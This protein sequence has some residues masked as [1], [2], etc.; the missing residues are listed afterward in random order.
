MAMQFITS[1]T[2]PVVHASERKAPEYE[3]I[4]Y[5]SQYVQ[6]SDAEVQTFLETLK[7]RAHK[8]GDFLLKE[9][10]VT[11]LCC[12]VLKGCIRQYYLVDGEEKTTNFFTEG[13]PVASPEGVATRKPAKFYLT[14]LEDT[15]VM[16]GLTID[17]V[18]FYEKFP[19]L[20]K[21]MQ[22]MIEEEMAKQQ[23]Q[24]ANFIMFSPEERYLNLL[25]NR[26]E[27]LDR[28]PHYQLA[29]YLGVK[30]ESLS[31]IRKRIMVK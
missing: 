11:E 21:A 19:K 12:F 14:C 4:K 7:V 8:K 10:Q 31:R 3:L 27:L 24:F 15:I 16:T 20:A 1:S 29:S 9:G 22:V 6:L 18:M 28:V 25:K 26:P 13:Q 30:P 5:I 23:D 2:I 17:E